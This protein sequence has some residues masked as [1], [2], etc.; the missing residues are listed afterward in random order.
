MLSKEQMKM[1]KG[2]TESRLYHCVAL[3]LGP[4]PFYTTFGADNCE[5][6]QAL[7]DAIAWS[8]QL[9]NS[10]PNGGLVIEC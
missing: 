9:T 2:G 7:C 8:D 1:V 5:M 3:P 10:Y 6:A 4:N